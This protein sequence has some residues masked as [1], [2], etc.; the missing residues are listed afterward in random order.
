[1]PNI[2]KIKVCYICGK[3]EGSHWASHWKNHHPGTEARVLLP[4]EAPTNPI[5]DDWLNPI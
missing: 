3:A 4:G 1:M 2:R 5:Y